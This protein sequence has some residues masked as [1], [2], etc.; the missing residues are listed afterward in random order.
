[1]HIFADPG[2]ENTVYVL[3]APFLKSIDGGK[4][5]DRVTV[6][7]GDNHYLWINPDDSD[8]M[9]N[10]NDGGAN[11]SFDGGTTW[12]RQDNQPTAQ[13]YRVNTDNQFELTGRFMV[14]AK[15]HLLPW[16]MIIR[17]IPTPAVTS[18]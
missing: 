8:W 17:A 2:D 3:N 14:A 10:A 18:A 5:F 13:F 12:S 9:V 15:V 16:M 6:P 4:S 1:M 7:H 11:V